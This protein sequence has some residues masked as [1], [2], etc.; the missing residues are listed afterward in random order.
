M[1]W[2]MYLVVA[3]PALLLFLM[4]YLIRYR[5]MY[6]LMSG[7]NTMSEEKKKNVDV[8]GLG[9][10]L[11]GMLFVMGFLIGVGMLLLVVLEQ[12]AAGLG[13]LALEL[14]VVVLL[15]VRAQTFDG[16][17]KDAEGR[18]KKGT[19]AGLVGIVAFL[20]LL[21]GGIAYLFQTGTQPIAVT[22]ENGALTISGLYGQTVPV[23][24]I[25]ALQT[26]D[27]LPAVEAR[28]NGSAMGDSL[29]GHFRLAGVGAAMLYVDQGKPPF[30]YLE[31]ATQK[32]Y[33]NLAT[34]AE[35]QALYEAISISL[36]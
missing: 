5:K 24:E 17:A 18:L 27:A 9:R 29:S 13:V 28:T 30:L 25:T 11:G 22:F 15:L 23:S 21:A 26:V 32:I 12:T 4:G 31:T 2:M 1:D 6:G 36:E 7:F 19:K 20:V 33:L 34:P 35:T 14:P 10:F 3:L 8:E 16:N